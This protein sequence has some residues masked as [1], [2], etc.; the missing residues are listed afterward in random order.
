MW[1]DAADRPGPAGGPGRAVS[2]RASLGIMTLESPAES[3]G[4]GA[5][6]PDAESAAWVRA[7]SAG[8][9]GRDDA[10][11]RLHA[12]LLRVAR[13]ELARRGGQLRISGPELDDLAHQATAPRADGHRR[14]GPAA[15]P[16][17]P[18]PRP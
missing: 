6:A 3:A 17:R 1:R 9:A 14:L 5:R 15:G 18:G 10:A 7:L 13:A 12:A 11:A 8:G 4:E 2:A 16:A